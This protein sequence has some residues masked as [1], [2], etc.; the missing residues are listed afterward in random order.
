MTQRR[1]SALLTPIFVAVLMTSTLGAQ[2]ETPA[3]PAQPSDG[4]PTRTQKPPLH[5]SHWIAITGKPLAAAAG[6]MIFQKGGNAV[7]AAAAMLAAACTMWV[8]LSCGGETQ[9]LIYNPH[10]KMVSGINAL[11]VEPSGATPAY[12]K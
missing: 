9:A 6:A 3:R 11:G 4:R 2:E 10:T 7:D 8:T 1:V 12:S 5:G